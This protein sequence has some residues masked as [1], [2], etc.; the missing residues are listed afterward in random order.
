MGTDLKL[1]QIAQEYKELETL[2][3]DLPEEVVRD[4]LESL[5]G[6]LTDKVV[7][8]T[9]FVR[10]VE[11]SAEAINEVAEQM[12]QRATRM[13]NL[14]ERIKAY[15]LANMELAGVTKIECP[16]FSVRVQANPEAVL[17]S[18]E[19][20]VPPEYM[21]QPE[22]PPPRPDKKK[23]KEDLK[24]GKVIEGCWLTKGAHLRIAV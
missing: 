20:L 17:I 18:D 9:K 16:L 19:A 10:N 11:A 15:M 22:P 23:I 24:A 7:S 3:D 21:V 13:K 6:E 8:I 4:T 12:H 2:A 14:T 1:Y 5:K